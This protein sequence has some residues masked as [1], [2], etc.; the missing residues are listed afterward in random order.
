MT[1]TPKKGGHSNANW[2]CGSNTDELDVKMR[3]AGEGGPGMGLG[4]SLES[5]G[6]LA[7]APPGAHPQPQ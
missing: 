4:A 2:S 1:K 3:L 7:G 5:G 6:H